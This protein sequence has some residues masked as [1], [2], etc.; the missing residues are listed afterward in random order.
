MDTLYQGFSMQFKN[1]LGMAP[2]TWRSFAGIVPSATSS[3]VYPFLEQFGGM[4]EW[5]G[6][7][8]VK[9]FAS[10]KLEVVN[11]DYEDTVS[12]SAN[13]IEDDQYGLYGTLIAQMGC[14]SG[15]LWNDLAYEALVSNSAWLDG[16]AFFLTTR[17]YGSN[18]INNKTTSALSETTFNTA[19]QTML[20]YKGHNSKL[21]GVVPDLL[22]VGPKLRTAAWSIVK[23]QFAYDA[24]DKVQTRNVNENVVDLL[25]APELVGSYDD[26]WFLASTKG[27]LKPVMVQQRKEPV[28]TRLDNDTDENVFMRKEFIYGTHARGAAFMSMPHLV[29]A[30]IL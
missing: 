23:D 16:S 27:V 17:K 4:R 5:I 24:A 14:N 30:G 6:D 2:D 15:K 8:E 7:R 26:Y 19:Y 22:I 3:N 12:V 28:L 13:D 25:V 1:G 29:Y 20:E 10:K 11:N 18:T 21:L 9:S